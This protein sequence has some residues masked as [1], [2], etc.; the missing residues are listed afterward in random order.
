MQLHTAGRIVFCRTPNNASVPLHKRKCTQKPCSI[1]RRG[2]TQALLNSAALHHVILHR[3]INCM[4]E[5]S[6]ETCENF[7]MI[8]ATSFTAHPNEE[9]VYKFVLDTL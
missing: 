9:T 4:G 7:I 8:L 5:L 1:V 3:Q 6:E 2:P